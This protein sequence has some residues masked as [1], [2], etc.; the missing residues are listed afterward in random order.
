MIEAAEDKLFSKAD[1]LNARDTA[2]TAAK[3]EDEQIRQELEAEGKSY[4]EYRR[5]KNNNMLREIFGEKFDQIDILEGAE[6][7]EAIQRV[8]EAGDHPIVRA[9]FGHD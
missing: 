6:K 7:E 9:Y 1:R 2:Q 5:E 3:A 8:K 4:E